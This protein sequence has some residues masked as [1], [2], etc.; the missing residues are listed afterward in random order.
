MNRILWSIHIACILLLLVNT[1]DSK[2][3]G[4]SGSRSWGRSRG[5]GSSS[6]SISSA[7]RNPVTHTSNTYKPSAPEQPVHK[8][9]FSNSF[10]PSAPPAEHVNTVTRPNN[11]PIGFVQPDTATPFG[12]AGSGLHKNSQSGGQSSIG[13]EGLNGKA[14]NKPTGVNGNEHIQQSNVKPVGTS[15]GSGSNGFASSSAS[16]NTQ[17]NGQRPIGFEGFGSPHGSSNNN[18]GSLQSFHPSNQRPIGFEGYGSPS[19]GVHKNPSSSSGNTQSSYPGSVHTPIQQNTVKPSYTGLGNG[20][21]YYQPGQSPYGYQSGQS[22]YGYQPGQSPYGQHPYGNSYG[23]AYGGGSY[24]PGQSPYS[25]YPSNNWGGSYQSHHQ[26]VNYGPVTYVQNPG[27]S[28]YSNYHYS[29]HDYGSGDYG[30]FLGYALGRLGSP[31]YSYH[32]YTPFYSDHYVVH[33]YHHNRESV[34]KE[35][36]VQPN[37]VVA[38]A[39]NASVL[40]SSHTTALCMSNGTI[41]CVA[42]REETVP[43]QNDPSAVCIKTE[44]PCINKTQPGCEDKN[45]TVI[46]LPCVSNATVFGNLTF[47]NNSI[48]LSDPVNV[49]SVSGTNNNVLT[50]KDTRI[51]NLFCIT[52]IAEPSVQKPNPDAVYEKVKETFTG[53]L[54]KAWGAG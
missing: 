53:F 51:P 46:N 25:H 4:S 7:R 41:M 22:P 21:N 20:G 42:K 12:S 26:H 19:H 9:V 14:Q 29:S 38:C 15:P 36:T 34:P 33:H 27:Y 24:Y 8:T 37:T 44:I 10:K 1:G 48:V 31:S 54:V 18:G 23:H 32:S 43:C 11:R 28:G 2:R 47:T 52:V 50:V 39:G 3:F 16:Q 5:R 30:F 13:F 35:I 40:C 6:G 45:T 49:T 17:L